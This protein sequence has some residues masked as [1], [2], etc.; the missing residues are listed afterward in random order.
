MKL[1]VNRVHVR[2]EDDYLNADSPFSFGIVIDVRLS[3]LKGVI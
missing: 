3:C 2:Y 1:R